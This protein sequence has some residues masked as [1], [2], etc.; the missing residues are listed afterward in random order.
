MTACLVQEQGCEAQVL[1][2]EYCGPL[3]AAQYAE[4][5]AHAHYT[6][7][8]Q[9]MSLVVANTASPTPAVESLLAQHV[10]SGE[11]PDMRSLFPWL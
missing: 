4:L 2:D 11:D 3:N 9:C 5:L 10:P 8:S 7:D 6:E 1:K